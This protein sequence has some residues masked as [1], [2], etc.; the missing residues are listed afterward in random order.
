MSARFP[1]AAVL[2]VAITFALFYLMSVLI[3]LNQ[4]GKEEQ[5]TGT[6]IEFVRVKKDEETRTKERR[7]PQKVQQAK[8]PP[9]PDISMPRARRPDLANP[10]AAVVA[11]PTSD[12]AAAPRAGAALSDMDVVPLVRIAPEYPP[13]AARM[14]ISGWV[15]LEFTVTA[16]GTT[17][18]VR[19]VDSDPPGTFDRAATRAVE[20][21]KY[22]PKIENG[23]PVPRSGVQIVLRFEPNKE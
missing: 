14:G 10:N 21:F 19:V 23:K 15:L 11:L 9:P 18:D 7:L 4:R 8:Q 1:I 16:A 17:D 12:L 6:T 3:E 22:R 20:K 2:A 5:I 13:R